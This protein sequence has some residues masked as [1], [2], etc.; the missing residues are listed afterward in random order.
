MWC[1]INKTKSG[2]DTEEVDT[3]S[4]VAAAFV[5]FVCLYVCFSFYGNSVYF[6]PNKEHW[7]LIS[8][9]VIPE[10]WFPVWPG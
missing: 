4:A 6:S 7:C 3:A 1:N 10:F 5:V 2:C 9:F 8:A